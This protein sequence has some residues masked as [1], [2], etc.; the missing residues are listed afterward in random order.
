MGFKTVAPLTALG[1]RPKPSLVGC[2]AMGI[3]NREVGEVELIPVAKGIV[4]R[5]WIVL[6]VAL[7]G[8]VAMWSQESDL[9]TT[10]SMTAINRIYES[11]DELSLLSIVGID[12]ATV[13]PLPSFDNQILQVQEQASREKIAQETGVSSEV[14]I[15]RSE[16]RF[17]LLN[18]AEGDGKT[19]FTFLSVGTPT[20]SFNCSDS[21]AETCNT[22]IDA[23]VAALS[24][25]RRDSIVA[26]MQ[27]VKSMLSTV[28]QAGS[29]NAQEKIAG[30][31][32]AL[33][34][35]TG[36][37]ALLSTSE[38]QYGGTITS[39]KKTT[40]GFGFIAGAL[41]GLLIALQLTIIDK[42]VRSVSQLAKHVE[43]TDILGHATSDTSSIQHVAAA[44]VARANRQSITSI[45]LVPAA[46]A[47][48]TSDLAAKLHAI[49]QPLGVSVN[50][51]ASVSSIDAQSLL[52]MGD[53][54]VVVAEA[55]RSTTDDVVKT[56]SVLQSAQRSVL[57]TILVDAQH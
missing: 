41:I 28:A 47:G 5:W 22:A 38:D 17:S 31:D 6:I 52:S 43:R 15:T 35:I 30:I 48:N 11:R 3:L 18:T 4:S 44:L 33:P 14:T 50:A 55:K 53:G 46:S 26:G 37:L 13:S 42:R 34:L 25:V 51:Q 9:S 20:Y 2:F 12:P 21:T 10:P 7:L 40:Y 39:V 32:A 8:T 57:G 19:K 23:Y 56:W 16:Q 45:A 54:A 27:R 24:K 1:N 49:T 36:E 29:V